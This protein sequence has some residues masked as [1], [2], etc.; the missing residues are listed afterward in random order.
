MSLCILVCVCVCVCV[1]CNSL[2]EH[3]VANSSLDVVTVN[4]RDAPRNVNSGPKQNSGCAWLKTKTALKIGFYR[5]KKA[6]LR[7]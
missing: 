1:V 7:I 6:Y 5:K 3:V 4:G 2:K